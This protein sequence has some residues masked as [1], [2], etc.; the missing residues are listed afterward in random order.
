MRF[1]RCLI[2]SVIFTITAPAIGG[3]ETSPLSLIGES[4]QFVEL[5][6]KRIARNTRFYDRRN[7]PTDIGAYRGKVVLV[8]FWASWCLPCMAEMPSLDQLA[9]DHSNDDLVI[10]P[11]SIDEDGLLAAIPFYRRLGLENLVLFVD[12]NGETA[13]SNRDNPKNAEFALYG[14]PITYA[15]DR[16][17]RILGYV[18]GLVDWQSD[19]AADFIDRLLESAK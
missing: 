3:A 8:N 2:V 17:G 11:V 5:D 13:Y 12:P 4:S 18:T 1:L 14:L 6:P 16:T 15:L 10:I 9:Y 7:H 19:N